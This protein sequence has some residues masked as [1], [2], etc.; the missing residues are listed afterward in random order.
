[1]QIGESLP[2]RISTS[3]E[4]LWDNGKV[5]V[6]SCSMAAVKINNSFWCT[7][8]KYWDSVYL[9]NFIEDVEMSFMC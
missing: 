8:L 9:W 2:Y 5:L 4:V 1:M 3:M 6:S 7:S